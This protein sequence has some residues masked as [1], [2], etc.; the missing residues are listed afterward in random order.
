M[1]VEAGVQLLKLVIVE[2]QN[3]F[4]HCSL[5]ALLQTWVLYAAV[6]GAKAKGDPQGKERHHSGCAGDHGGGDHG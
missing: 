4:L 2:G 1:L 5:A 6:E 3:C